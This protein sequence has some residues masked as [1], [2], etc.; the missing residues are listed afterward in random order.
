MQLGRSYVKKVEY[1]REIATRPRKIRSYSQS[2]EVKVDAPKLP[3]LLKR[4]L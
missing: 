1:S 3:H 2:V 4:R